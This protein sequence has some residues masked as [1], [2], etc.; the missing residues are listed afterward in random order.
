[1]PMVLG[2]LDV[3]IGIGFARKR[4]HFIGSSG[5]LETQ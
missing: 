3:P 5:D 2:L 4:F 1:M